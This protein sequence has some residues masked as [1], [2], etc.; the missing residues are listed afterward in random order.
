MSGAPRIL[1]MLAHC[2]LHLR[3]SPVKQ[4][5]KRSDRDEY[6]VASLRP[7]RAAREPIGTV[8]A[9]AD[10]MPRQNRPTVGNRI[11]IAFAPIP[12]HVKAAC[13]PQVAS[14]AQ[15]ET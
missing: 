11:Q 12:R 8:Q 1:G 5:P 2:V 14:P 3:I 13:P 7:N 15:R 4:D 10:Q 6:E 9:G